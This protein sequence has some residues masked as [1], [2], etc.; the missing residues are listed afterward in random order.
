MRSERLSADVSRSLRE[1]AGGCLLSTRHFTLFDPRHRAAHPHIA[2]QDRVSSIRRPFSRTTPPAFRRGIPIRSPSIIS[3]GGLLIRSPT[4]FPI[5]SAGRRP[6]HFA[7]PPT[8]PA[9]S[10]L[11]PRPLPQEGVS[12]RAYIR[13]TVVPG[14]VSGEQPYPGWSRRAAVSSSSP[15]Y[16][17][18]LD[19]G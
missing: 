6:M 7:G 12:A 4:A 19:R 5:P 1:A 2:A 17:H 16:P 9:P 15:A 18:S 11:L 14:D 8:T 10:A 13:R 3:E